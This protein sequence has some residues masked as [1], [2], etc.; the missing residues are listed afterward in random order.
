MSLVIEVKVVP[1]SKTQAFSLDKQGILKCYLKSQPEKGK[2][3]EELIKL[4]SK[5]LKIPQDH[6]KVLAGHTGRKKIIKLGHDTLTL[7]QIYELCGIE[8]QTTIAK[9]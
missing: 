7:P 2:A 3:N 4:L 9:K 5:T 1:G 6:I 8:T